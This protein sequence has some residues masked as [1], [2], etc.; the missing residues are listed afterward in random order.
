MVILCYYCLI[1]TKVLEKLCDDVFDSLSKADWKEY[2]DSVTRL[3][4]KDK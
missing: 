4:Q 3:T 2:D 1:C